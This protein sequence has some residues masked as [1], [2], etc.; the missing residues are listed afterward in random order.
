MD[1]RK[2]LG[3]KAR[4]LRKAM[5]K[6]QGDVAEAV[7][8]YR[9]DL[10][11]FEKHGDKLGIDKIVSLFGYFGYEL[12]VVEKK[13]AVNHVTIKA[14]LRQLLQAAEETLEEMDNGLRPGTPVQEHQPQT[15]HQFWCWRALLNI[16]EHR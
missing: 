13:K 7:D 10:S 12:T 6:T 11:A 8:I 5:N 1:I 15:N 16:V 2:E 4:E 14:R 3:K 9:N